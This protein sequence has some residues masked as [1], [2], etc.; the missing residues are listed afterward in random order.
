MPRNNEPSLRQRINEIE[1]KLAN[2]K[3]RSDDL[4]REYQDCCIAVEVLE[5][6]AE[7]LRLEYA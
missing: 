5:G 2:A 1:H 6:E 7:Q 3:R 4:F